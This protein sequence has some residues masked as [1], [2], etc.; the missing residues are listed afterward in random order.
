MLILLCPVLA[1][2]YCPS[3]PLWPVKPETDLSLL[4]CFKRHVPVVLSWPPATSCPVHAV[5]LPC[6]ISFLFSFIISTLLFE[7][8]VSAVVF[9]L[10]S[11]PSHTV[12]ALLPQHPCPQLSCHACPVFT[13]MPWLACP[14]CPARTDL[15]M[16]I[17]QADPSRRPVLAVLSQMSN[18][19]PSVM[20][21]VLGV[22]SWLYCLC[23]HDLAVLSSLSCPGST[24]QSRPFFSVCTV[25]ADLSQLPSPRCPILAVFFQLSWPSCPARAL[26][27]QLSCSCCPVL[28]SMSWPPCYLSPLQTDL[29]RLTCQSGLSRLTC[30]GCPV[31]VSCTR[32]PVPTVLSFVLDRLFNPYCPVLIAVFLPSCHPLT[33]S[34]MAFKVTFTVWHGG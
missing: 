31:S 18:P 15:S 12:S 32:F 11:R 2:M 9:R 3:C 19:Y 23:W 7:C 26:L 8:P 6:L 14:L 16:L 13:V 10:P 17:R 24:V 29:S 28:D 33:L 20:V 21:P 25:S 4:S 30:Q 22:L 27:S 1:V 34:H 5:L